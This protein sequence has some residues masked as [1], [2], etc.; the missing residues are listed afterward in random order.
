MPVLLNGKRVG[1]VTHVAPSGQGT[2]VGHS[3]GGCIADLKVQVGHD[4]LRNVGI[5][6]V[7]MPVSP[8]R[9][10]TSE[11]VELFASKSSRGLNGSSLMGFSSFEEL[12]SSDKV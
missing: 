6:L 1:E 9:V 7:N 11:S 10:S 5:A 12:W 3:S 4:T 2:S 8:N